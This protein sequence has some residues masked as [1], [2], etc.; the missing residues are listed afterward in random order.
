MTASILF[1]VL[2][3]PSN[4]KQVTYKIDK[5]KIPSYTSTKAIC[6][7]KK[8]EKTIVFVSFT[9]YHN[10]FQDL[11]SSSYAEATEKM[12]KAIKEKYDS[13]KDLT[14]ECKNVEF[15]ISPGVGTF[16]EQKDQRKIYRYKEKTSSDNEINLY[17]NH[18]YYTTFSTISQYEKPQVYVDLTHGINYMP[19]VL[20]NVVNT[21]LM[22]HG[23]G[24]AY[25]FNSDPFVGKYSEGIELNVNEINSVNLR[26]NDSF[27]NVILQFLS[28]EEEY[29]ENIKDHYKIYKLAK[30]AL[31]GVY[32]LVFYH[33]KLIN[34]ALEE[35]KQELSQINNMKID[36]KENNGEIEITYDYDLSMSYFL[37]HSLLH[38]LSKLVNYEKIDEYTIIEWETRYSN[39][40]IAELLEYQISDIIN[41]IRDGQ[42]KNT[43]KG[44]LHNIELRHYIAHAGLLNEIIHV[45]TDPSLKHIEEI[46]YKSLNLEKT[47][48][49]L[50]NLF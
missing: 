47:L 50:L 44:N 9:L 32:I 41:K 22:A 4:Y 2:G 40:A 13:L 16:V 21:A 25:F 33:K 29:Y 10:L 8:V 48:E 26:S 24:T 31:A 30:A 17:F 23:E 49:D 38:T 28:K 37:A 11:P 20:Y 36:V 3:D 19:I 39:P 34:S 12:K 15:V 14:E 45:K 46:E 7:S 6:I 1:S 27:N 35:V 43:T 18:V 5:D 42:W